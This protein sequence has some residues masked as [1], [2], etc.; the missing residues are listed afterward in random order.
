VVQVL[1]ASETYPETVDPPL[2]PE[3]R[4]FRSVPFDARHRNRD[5]ATPFL[6]RALLHQKGLV[7]KVLGRWLDPG[8]MRFLR[9]ELAITKKKPAL[10]HSHSA[11]AGASAVWAA[12]RAGI[13]LVVS[14][15]GSDIGRAIMSERSHY[16]LAS[17][18]D[19]AAA[20]L[21]EGPRSAEDLRRLGCSPRKV[22][23]VPRPVHV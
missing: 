14:V 4:R 12:T 11:V 21:V 7:R 17:V 13:P 22:M 5:R 18:F 20:V 3:V 16:I 10:V 2:V 23:M 8:R 19:A 15:T 1:T 6:T 9:L